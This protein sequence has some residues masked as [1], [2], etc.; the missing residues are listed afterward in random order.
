MISSKTALEIFN[1]Q[2]DNNPVYEDFIAQSGKGRSYAVNRLKKYLFFLLN[3][4]G[5]IK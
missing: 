5:I 1:Y 3:F 4:S 2:R